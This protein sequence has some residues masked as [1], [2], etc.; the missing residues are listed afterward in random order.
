MHARSANYGVIKSC[1]KVKGSK[2][3]GRLKNKLE[4]L[5]LESGFRENF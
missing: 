3:S 2:F 1:I 4:S 5:Q